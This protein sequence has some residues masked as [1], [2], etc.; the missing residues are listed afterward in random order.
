MN[1]IEELALSGVQKPSLVG[2][3]DDY[4]NVC[5]FLLG[6]DSGAHRALLCGFR[7]WLI[8]RLGGYEN[9]HW[10][11][12]ILLLALGESKSVG[13]L[14]KLSVEDGRLAIKRLG[15]CLDQFF[16]VRG[17]FD[18]L[19]R[20]FTAHEDWLRTQNWYTPAS[21]HWAGPRSG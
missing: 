11:Q 12:L 9:M 4:S 1:D 19:R 8:L 7:E 13:D 18:G 15:E 20:I 17:K 5:A 16:E 3:S 2:I 14:R 10:P 21:P 6:L